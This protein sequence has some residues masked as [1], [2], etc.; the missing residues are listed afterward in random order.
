MFKKNAWM[1]L[2]VGTVSIVTTLVSPY[3]AAHE[4]LRYRTVERP[5]RVCRQE[6]VEDSRR[7][8]TGAVLGGVAGGLLGSQI[9]KGNGST[10]AAVLGAGTGAVMGDHIN[11][12]RNQ[13]VV[14]HCHTVIKHVRVPIRSDRD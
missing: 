5:Q 8:Y 7:D 4:T 12:K 3:V 1:A 11:R 6:V 13:R 14:Q 9:G 10:A 2:C